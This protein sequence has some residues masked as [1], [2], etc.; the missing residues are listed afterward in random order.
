MFTRGPRI[1]GDDE[2]TP[3]G[4]LSRRIRGRRL[5]IGA[6]LVL[7]AAGG[8][9]LVAAAG[10]ATTTCT[11]YW[12]GND[13]VSNPKQA[14]EWSDP[15]NWSSTDGGPAATQTPQPMD[16]VCMSTNPAT[17]QVTLDQTSATVGGIN[18]PSTGT[19]TVANQLEIGTVGPTTIASVVLGSPG[20]LTPDGPETVG[21][22]TL[23]GG[24]L[25]G[26]GTVP[27]PGRWRSAVEA[28]PGLPTWSR[29]GPAPSRPVRPCSCSMRRSWRSVGR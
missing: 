17:T 8:A 28:C 16:Y 27:T 9:G 24:T 25:N 3:G 29:T 18:W 6:I 12:T 1:D 22:L 23:G 20:S 13:G 2:A 7:V 4:T 14:N 15:G 10:S 19:L 26:P 11:I 5:A 21:G